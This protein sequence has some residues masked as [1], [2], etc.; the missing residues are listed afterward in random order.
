MEPTNPPREAARENTLAL[1]FQRHG[2]KGAISARQGF[3]N[4]PSS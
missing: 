1:S 3:I 4:L 2:T